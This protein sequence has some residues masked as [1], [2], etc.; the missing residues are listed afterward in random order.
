M[1]AGLLVWLSACA[2]LNDERLRS[3]D[4]AD[5]AMAGEEAPAV[6]VTET[7]TTQIL[8]AELALARNQPEA[9]SQRYAKAARLAGE[10]ALARRATELAMRVDETAR[11]LAMAERWQA[12]D[13]DSIE[14]HQILGVMQLEQGD[15]EQARATLVE[16]VPSDPEAREAAIGR[17]GALLQRQFPAQAGVAVMQGITQ[18]YSDS[19]SAQLALGRLALEAGERSVAQQAV[20]QALSLRE[21]W[22]A[23]RLLRADILQAQQ[24]PDAALAEMEA[25]LVDS[26]DSRALRRDYARMLVQLDR[27][28]QALA[29]Y[30]RLF[31]AGERG[32]RAL[33]ITAVLAI[34]A[35]AYDLAEAVL[36][37]M[38]EG[39][40]GLALES[41]AL[42]G[43][44]L[45]TR[46]EYARS[47][48]T[49]NEGL[50]NHPRSTDLRYGR[51]LTRVMMGQVDRAVSELQALV[52]ERPDDP[53]L[54]N[55]LGYTLIDQTDRL[56]DGTALIEQAYD[57]AP[58]NPAIIDSMGWAAYLRGH[59]AEALEYLRTAHERTQDD[60]EIAAHLG[61][62]LWVLGREAEARSVWEAALDNQPDHPVLRRTQERLD[63]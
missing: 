1:V 49:L 57:L 14:A 7:I 4:R 48:A 28:E 25:L 37:A 38:R 32:P 30:Q 42:E 46:G 58:D 62:V 55:A 53:Q 11:A 20:D 15:V 16:G 51:A 35:E 54:L 40:A 47:L 39:Q 2:P 27:P 18:T 34:N 8:A 45:R 63:P 21:D 60:P 12:L 26:P 50:E 23:A 22:T 36:A 41:W 13:P 3:L 9:A 33:N 61:E 52:D 31:E 5:T 29:Q 17:L 56:D 19:P 44:M 59:P 24:R 6:S 43:D 10:P